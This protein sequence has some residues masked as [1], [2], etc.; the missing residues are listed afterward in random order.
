M[1]VKVTS[2]KLVNQIWA[3]FGEILDC[4]NINVADKTGSVR[5]KFWNEDGDKVKGG[6][7]YTLSDG[8]VKA[9]DGER[10]VSMSSKCSVK[11]VEDIGDVCQGNQVVS[12]GSLLEAM[13]A[14][15]I[16]CSNVDRY[17]SCLFCSSKVKGRKCGKCACVKPEHYPLEICAK[18]H[19]VEADLEK[20]SR[21]VTLQVFTKHIVEITK[22]I[23]DLQNLSRD[24][25]SDIIIESCNVVSQI[26]QW[27]FEACY[28]TLG[29][30]A[31]GILLN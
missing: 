4:K 7:S 6:L 24:E 16:G 19:V 22:T 27:C 3:S 26:L 20:T 29:G 8:I 2:I 25:I 21:S 14:E 1:N 31:G 13:V 12:S 10:Y 15:I 11:E 23:R 18:I 30:G 28:C 5:V 9:Y 17:H